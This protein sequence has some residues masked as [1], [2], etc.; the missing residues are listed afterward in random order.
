MRRVHLLLACVF[1]IATLQFSHPATSQSSVSVELLAQGA[2]QLPPEA[3]QAVEH[4]AQQLANTAYLIGLQIG[5]GWAVG[6]LTTAPLNETHHDHEEDTHIEP[7]NLFA[8]LL[9]ETETR[10]Q[11]ALAADPTITQLLAY[12]PTDEF[13]L[14]A[15][16]AIFPPPSDR[17]TNESPTQQYSNYKLP[18]LAG[19]PWAR[20]RS[21]LGWHGSTWSGRFPDNNSLDFDIINETNADILVSA[22]GVVTHMCQIANEQQAGVVIKTQGT[23][24]LLG[25]LHLQSASIPDSVFIGASLEQGNYLGRMVEGN[26]SETCGYSIGTHL[27]MFLPTRPFT[28]DG[29]TFSDTDTQGGVRLFSTQSGGNPFPT[30]PADTDLV[31]NGDFSQGFDRWTTR[32]DTTATVTDINGDPALS[33]KGISGAA[34]I[35][36]QNINYSIP[37]GSTLEMDIELGNTSSVT[38][39]LR[40]HVHRYDDE[41]IWD[42]MLVCDFFVPASTPLQ[43]YTLRH[44]IDQTWEDT[45]IWIESNP[46]DSLDSTLTDSV[47]LRHYAGTT[48]DAPQCFEPTSLTAWDFTTPNAWTLDGTLSTPTQSTYSVNGATSYLNSPTLLAVSADSYPYLKI[49]LASSSVDL[50]PCVLQANRATPVQ[51]NTIY[52]I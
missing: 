6:T 10:W 22:P 25:Y 46:A 39:H 48:L 9:V 41:A 26:I 27:H 8:V 30:A 31:H 52:P 17:P 18:W 35:I 16:T 19:A 21:G 14:E 49:N 47:R 37:A 20:T 43:H 32:E 36:T 40:V 1:I 4:A 51:R 23:E 7:N 33:W 5:S 50:H 3:I 12:I 2:D 38:K 13:S 34:G 24:E 29:Y 42:D 28:M 45:R 44:Q 15:R 11:S